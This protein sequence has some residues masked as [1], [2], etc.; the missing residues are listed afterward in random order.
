MKEAEFRNELQGRLAGVQQRLREQALD[1]MLLLHKTDVL[2]L[3]GS[4]QNAHLWVGSEGAP[5]L[6]VKRSLVRAR[7]DSPL[8]HIA[9][10]S[11]LRELPALIREHAG[12]LP[13]RLG[14]ELDVLPAS[15]YLGYRRLF[16]KAEL[17]DIAPLIRQARMVKSDHEIALITR[18]AAMADELFGRIPAFLGEAASES[19]LAVRAEGFYRRRG[20]P[21]LVRTR[22]FNLEC[23]YGHILAGAAGAVPSDAPGPTGG[24][25][26]GPFFSQG[27][28]EAPITPQSPIVV[29][30]ASSVGGYI[31]DQTRIFS[32]GRLADD[33]RRAHDTMLEVRQAV[34]SR[35]RP[36]A[37]AGDLYQCAL[38]VVKR[39]GLEEGF[40]GYPDPVPFIAH[41]VGLEID[42]WPVVGRNSD[43]LLESGMTLALEPKFVFPGRGV[44]GI[45]NTF[46]VTE[47]G[48]QSLN[49]FPEEICEV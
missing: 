27:G 44:V 46:V 18:A 38:D 16:P 22:G 41:G 21:G 7:A 26:Y 40:M 3:S 2:Y 48:M 34:A 11:S 6:L 9:G 28:G 43:Q 23:V 35:G 30:Y 4:D 20:H 29:D 33:L 47:R 12:R 37:R 31:S 39:A 32:L 36:G 5:L 8:E 10:L 15:L 45:E 1:G 19:D 25:G 17:V 14:L 49:L 13:R 42:E 24:R